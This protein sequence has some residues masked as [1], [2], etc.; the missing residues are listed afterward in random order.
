MYRIIIDRRAGKEIESLPDT[1]LQ[2]IIDVIHGLRSNPRP[3]GVK[4]LINRDGWRIRVRDHRIL[5]TVDDARK[6]ISIYRVKH[7]KDAYR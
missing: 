2:S 4:K 1:I 7:R 3:H 5:Y 6:T